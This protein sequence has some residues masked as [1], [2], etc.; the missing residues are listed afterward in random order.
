M[1]IDF[2]DLSKLIN[3]RMDHKYLNDTMK[4]PITAENIAFQ[5]W[6]AIYCCYKITVEETEGNEASYINHDFTNK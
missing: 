3:D 1:V 5:L 6:K 2:T 4:L